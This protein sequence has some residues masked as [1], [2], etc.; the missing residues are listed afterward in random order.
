MLSESFRCFLVTKD[1]EG[2]AHG[3]VA[4]K[5]L[6][7]LPAGEVLIRVAYSSLNY[8]DA[9]SATGH[10]GVTRHFPHVPG[11]DASGV[12]V[13][14]QSP[15]VDEGDEVFVTGFDLGQNTW[16]GFAEYVQVPGAWVMHLPEGLSLRESMIYGT[17]GLTA[18]ECV[19]ALQQVGVDPDQGEVV[20]TG[21]T[22]GVGSLAVAILAKAGYQVVASTGKRSAY[23][24]LNLLGARRCISRE[25]V[26]DPSTKPLLSIRWAGA[27][28]TVGGN[29]LATLVRSTGQNG[30]VAACGLVGGIELPLT[31]Y[32][33]ILR[34]VD[35]IGVDSALCPLETRARIWRKLAGEWKPKC[36]D[37]ILAEEIP[38]EALG[39]RIEKILAGQMVGRVI[40]RPNSESPKV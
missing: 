23:E 8:K 35:L 11:I 16:G 19:E 6:A 32:P 18:G 17:A 7:D 39:S 1:S 13:R 3:E 31:V 22:G 15:L 21:A 26:N 20:V 33:F 29:T 9:L 12:V 40:V 37:K 36:L 30:C 27:I 24:H 14:S 4:E 34:G 5:S 38:L 10:P 28:D 25:E 2:K